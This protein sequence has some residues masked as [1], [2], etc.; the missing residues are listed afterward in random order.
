MKIVYDEICNHCGSYIYDTEDIYQKLFQRIYNASTSLYYAI[1]FGRNKELDEIECIK[2]VLNKTNK[3][4]SELLFPQ[5]IEDNIRNLLLE[6]GLDARE[7]LVETP[8]LM[9]EDY[10]DLAKYDN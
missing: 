2:R 9:S 8:S 7:L 5:E 10:K 3:I 4:L 1:I 6:N